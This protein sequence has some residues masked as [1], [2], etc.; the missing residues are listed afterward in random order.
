MIRVN[1]MNV[2]VI[3]GCFWSTKNHNPIDISSSHE[4]GQSRRP[5]YKK[6]VKLYDYLSYTIMASKVMKKKKKNFFWKCWLRDIRYSW[7]CS[8]LFQPLDGMDVI[9]GVTDVS[10]RH[11]VSEYVMFLLVTEDL[12]DQSV[13]S[14]EQM[15]IIG[16]TK[17][18]GAEKK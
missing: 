3:V 10:N 2:N 13:E 11:E 14:A 18:V 12:L 8:N 9:R 16:K 1:I 5:G 17:M 15:W 6:K 4:L 7:Q